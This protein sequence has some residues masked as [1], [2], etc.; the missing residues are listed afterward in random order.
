ME[1]RVSDIRRIEDILEQHRGNAK[2]AVYEGETKFSYAELCQESDQIAQSFQKEDFAIKGRTV[3]FYLPKGIPYITAYFAVN[4]MGGI[5]VPIDGSCKQ[6]QFSS[7]VDY[8]DI[9]LIVTE[10]DWLGQVKEFLKELD[11][12][13]MVYCVDT[14]H[15]KRTGKYG[16]DGEER[17]PQISVT[18]GEDDVALLLHTS[19]TTSEPKRVM[20]THR[21]I[22]SN[23]RDSIAE[24]DMDQTERTLITLPFHFCYALIAQLLTHFYLG[25]SVVLYQ[26]DYNPYQ[27]LRQIEAYH[28]TNA[29]FVPSTLHLLC[30]IRAERYDIHSLRYLFM[31]GGFLPEEKL[32][33]VLEKFP[34]VKFVHT[35]GQTEASPRITQ[36]LPEQALAKLGSVGRPLPGIAVKVVKE[37]GSEASAGE[38]GEI[39]T[40]SDCVMPGYYKNPKET[41]KCIR[42]G[43]LHTGDL[44]AFD[45]E[46]YLYIKGRKKNMLISGGINL[47]PEEIEE[48]LGSHPAIREAVVSGEKHEVLGEVPVARLVREEG[49]DIT[50]AQLITYCRE[51]LEDYKIPV[52][53]EFVE[54]IEKTS[55]GKI[56]RWDISAGK[57]L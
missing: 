23:I 9:S 14:G 38:I 26:G 40:R 34:Q 15:L 21:N 43:W 44:G 33:L 28:C 8:C 25:G 20:L 31:G 18:G 27:V 52:R 39:L 5:V 54:Q 6:R 45:M 1:G 30:R 13:V 2:I 19:G 48:V 49:A 42:E 7:T 36:L 12:G 24:L 17:Y 56:L 46:G 53:M 37:D 4:R 10:E 3:L 32:R 29:N 51:Y 16:K 35:Y 41:L 57:I 22:L 47:Y 50:A 11:F 55:T